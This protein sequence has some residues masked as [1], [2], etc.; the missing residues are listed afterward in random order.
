VCV[1]APRRVL[2]S[3]QNPV[4]TFLKVRVSPALRMTCQCWK[5]PPLQG[6]VYTLRAVLLSRQ[7][8]VLTFLSWTALPPVTFHRWNAPPL[9]PCV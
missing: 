1:D 6:S 2:L 7:R 8:P 5:L 3:R 4:E 9:Q